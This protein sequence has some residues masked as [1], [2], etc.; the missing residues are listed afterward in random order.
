VVR[1]GL[2]EKSLKLVC[3]RPL[4]ALAAT[5]GSHDMPHTGVVCF[6]V[7]ATVVVGRGHNPLRTL[8]APLLAHGIVD[9]NVGRCLLVAARGHLA[10]AWGRAKFSHLATSG[11]LGCDIAHPLSGV[12][13]NVIWF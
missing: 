1:A 12:P 6:L 11:I 2:L 8:L 3:R 9:G 10:T 13:K 7:V 4:L 5:C